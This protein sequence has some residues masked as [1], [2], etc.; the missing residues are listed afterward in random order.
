[1]VI[2][3]AEIHKNGEVYGTTSHNFE[4]VTG[5]SFDFNAGS[6]FLSSTA[7]TLGSAGV[8]GENAGGLVYVRKHE[9][10]DMI[11]VDFLD[12]HKKG[13]EWKRPRIP[14]ENY[15]SIHHLGSASTFDYEVFVYK[16]EQTDSK[17]EQ[18]AYKKL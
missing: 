5:S 15:S 9:D 6:S 18:I 3:V 8:V 11:K 14:P 7:L 1:M 13:D 4:G 16:K 10:E 12:I 2:I 17:P